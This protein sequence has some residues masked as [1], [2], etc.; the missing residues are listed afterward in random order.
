MYAQLL[1]ARAELLAHRAVRQGW[2]GSPP[3]EAIRDD[4]S[5]ARSVLVELPPAD[6]RSLQARLRAVDCT[7]AYLAKDSAQA[8]TAGEE[9]LA[10]LRATEGLYVPRT[11]AQLQN[12]AFLKVLLGD[13][14]AANELCEGAYEGAVDFLGPEH[15][16]IALL[17]AQHAEVLFAAGRT[18]EGERQLHAALDLCLERMRVSDSSFAHVSRIVAN[19]HISR[20]L[21]LDQVRELTALI[22]ADS[23]QRF[24][25]DARLTL[26]ALNFHNAVLY[27]LELLNNASLASFERELGLW[28]VHHPLA[29]ISTVSAANRYARALNG[30]GRNEEAANVLAEYAHA[31]G[32][33]LQTNRN[34]AVSTERLFIN[35]LVHVERFAEAEAFLNR[36]Y[37]RPENGPGLQSAL[38]NH[39]GDLYEAWGRPTDAE[40]WRARAEQ[41]APKGP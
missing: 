14:D 21:R 19:K 39:Y 11:L 7:V 20:N 33:L 25:P 37:D 2:T 23:E 17:L 9:A 6:A 5:S 1:T 36:I 15:P 18:S 12:V 3:L 13:T 34:V 16:T 8:L 40:E 28:R 38:A 29:S 32:G 35:L 30:A 41:L 26:N 4:L 22:V 24:G 10:A 31:A 27:Q